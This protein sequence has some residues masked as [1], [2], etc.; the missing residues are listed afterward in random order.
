MAIISPYIYVALSSFQRAF[1]NIK[2][3]DRVLFALAEPGE[4][5]FRQRL[6]DYPCRSEIG[7]LAVNSLLK[8]LSNSE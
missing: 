1:P 8:S 7:L 3:F 4:G 5:R 6:A 2:L